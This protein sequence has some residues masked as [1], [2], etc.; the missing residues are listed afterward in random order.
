MYEE[1]VFMANN[2]KL[3]FGVALLCCVLLIQPVPA[4]ATAGNN[5]LY[6]SSFDSDPGWVTNNPSNDYWD[7]NLAAY[8]FNLEPATG[9]YAYAPVDYNGGSFTLEY[10]VTI[11]R[12]DEGATFRL[13]FSGT[14]MQRD[15][16][17]V[18]LTEFTNAKYGQIMWLRVVTQSA[19]ILQINSQHAATEL[20]PGAYEGPTAKY[21]LNTTY[22]VLVSYDDD[23]KIVST[24]I[25]DKTTGQEIWGYYIALADNLRGMN[26]IFIGTKGDYGMMNIYAQGYID[27]VRLTT[28]STAVQTPAPTQSVPTVAASFTT[29]PTAKITPTATIPTPYPTTTQ[30]SPVPVFVVIGALGISAIFAGMA[31]KRRK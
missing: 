8:H 7:P 12:I 28:P 10:D 24:K 25:T 31:S 29:R 6:Q 17:P 14:D 2:M 30:S 26:R 3:L 15:I 5:V 4:Q 16:G 27:N 9:N 20:E 22:H 19:K 1:G 18:V 11:N 13:G 23:Q 21:A